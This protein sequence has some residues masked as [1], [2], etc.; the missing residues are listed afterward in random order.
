M[1]NVE[2]VEDLVRRIA[3]DD[4]RPELVRTAAERIAERLDYDLLPNRDERAVFAFALP[5]TAALCF[6]R[7]W[8]FDDT[9]PKDIAFHGSTALEVE[10]MVLLVLIHTFSSIAADN[11]TFADREDRANSSLGAHL[12]NLLYGTAPNELT[13]DIFEADF[14]NRIC[15]MFHA[16]YGV[17]VTPL[18][19]SEA[20]YQQAFPS[21]ST[22]AV[23][24][25]LNDMK[26]VDESKLSWEQV[27]EFRRDAVSRRNFRRLV[28]WLDG[29]MA[30]KSRTYIADEIA[31]RLERYDA[32]L[33]KHG[34]QTILGT[35]AATLDAKYL[36]ASAAVVGAFAFSK[37]DISPFLTGGAV[38]IGSAAVHLA[39]TLLNTKSVRAEAAG[40]IA[41]VVQARDL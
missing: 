8:T 11:L 25:S 36:A 34:I 20:T 18:Y 39:Q 40:E 15:E 23:V 31:I 27:A 14:S 32:A 21:G 12:V 26:I 38:M 35:L 3:S 5:K 19:A 13:E 10:A 24:A 1:P 7:V 41:F 4:L 6:D 33:R 22:A 30:S 16:R 37:P 2:Y 29:A 17:A 28:H 9:A